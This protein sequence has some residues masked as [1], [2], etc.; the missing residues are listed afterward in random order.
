MSDAVNNFSE[1]LSARLKMERERRGWSLAELAQRS[2][3]SKAM[4]SRIE[5]NETSPTAALLGRL[6]GAF[7]LTLSALL[8]RLDETGEHVRR[9]RDQP[10]WTDPGSGYRRRQI[11]PAVAAPLELTQVRMPPGARVAFPA[12]SYAFIRQLIWVQEGTLSLVEGGHRLR[13]D[14]GDCLAFGSPQDRELRNDGGGECVYIV[15]VAR[16]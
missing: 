14:A 4:I 3:V 7:G 1:R 10:I 6:S 5:R 15:A 11:S 16:L 9:A 12:S 2:G 13:L 8:G